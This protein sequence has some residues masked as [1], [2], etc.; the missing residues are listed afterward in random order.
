MK[1]IMINHKEDNFME[2]LKDKIAI[3]TGGASGMGAA[4]AKRFIEEG[5][6]VIFTD[7]NEELGTA[8]QVEL[9]NQAEFYKHDVADEQQW[10]DLASL[11]KEKYGHVDVLVNNAGIG[12]NKPILDFPVDL[13]MRVVSVDQVS[14]LLGMKYIGG[15]MAKQGSGS[16]INIA[17]TSGLDGQIFGAAYCSAKWAVRALSKTGALEFAKYNVRVNCL[18]PGFVDTPLVSAPEYAQLR[19]NYE[20][21][22]PLGRAGKVSEIAKACLFLASDMSSYCNGTELVVDGG[23]SSNAHAYSDYMIRNLKMW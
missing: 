18:L 17:S 10:K 2:L 14:V 11:V 23:L 12:G 8:Y 3:V 9:G 4:Y 1:N 5:A 13:Y 15:L 21:T 6:R 7:I 20:T 19:A 22:I 16:I